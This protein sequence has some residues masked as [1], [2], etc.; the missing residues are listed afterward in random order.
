[1]SHDDADH[2]EADTP[3]E[4]VEQHGEGVL[5]VDRSNLLRSGEDRRDLK[6]EYLLL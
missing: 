2:R 6:P 1:M 3:G 4:L 5:P